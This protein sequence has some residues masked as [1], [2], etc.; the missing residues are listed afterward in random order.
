[1]LLNFGLLDAKVNKILNCQG[2]HEE[3]IDCVR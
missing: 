3:F 2:T 1:M